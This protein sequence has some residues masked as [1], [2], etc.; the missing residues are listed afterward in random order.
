VAKKKTSSARTKPSTKKKTTR[1]TGRSR[2]K[3]TT[4]PA[5]APRTSRSKPTS[6]GTRH[7]PAR[8]TPLDSEALRKI[9]SPLSKAELRSYRQ[10]L[11]HKRAEILGDMA[12]MSR[13]ALNSDSAN[14][15]HMPIH[16]ADVGSDHYE[17]ELTLGLVESERKLLHEIDEALERIADG[18][19][20]VCQAT[21]KP[22]G[23]PRLQAKPWAKYSIEAARELERNGGRW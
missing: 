23:K 20:G 22:I 10:L 2:A 7:A 13:D 12:S 14:L 5:R 21:G 8:I 9:K 18:T 15:S 4:S 16:M 17:Q 1:T 19:Y 3:A 6:N 11:L